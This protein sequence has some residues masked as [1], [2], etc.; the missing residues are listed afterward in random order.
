MV[1]E[2]LK[3][4]Y[5]LSNYQI[6][7]IAFL[8]KT[9]L[10]ESSKIL[11]MG[12]LF[13]SRIKLYL[14]ALFIMLFLRCTTGGLHFYSYAG[15]LAASVLYLWIAIYCLPCIPVPFY[16][17]VILLPFCALFCCLLGPAA[18][19]YR[20]DDCIQCYKK[21]RRIIVIFLFF[22]TAALCFISPAPYLTAG[23]WVIILH[24]LQLAAA[25]IQKKGRFKK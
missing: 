15:C 7:Q 24:T 4:N 22:Y 19:R 5:H 17:Q 18:S 21:C 11:F 10:S 20:S 2:Y 6:A 12:I 1:K 8:L 13:H 3:N 25:R 14:F 23:F 9:I 16:I